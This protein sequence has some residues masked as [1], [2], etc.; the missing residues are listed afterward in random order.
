MVDAIPTLSW[1]A[2][3][4]GSADFFNQ[5]WLDYTGLSGAPLGLDRRP[6]WPTSPGGE[7]RALR[8]GTNVWTRLPGFPG[9]AYGQRCRSHAQFAE[10]R[11]FIYVWWLLGT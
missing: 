8:A 7:F 2:R 6:D 9:S 4:D 10:C 1:S 3:A 11:N 5:S